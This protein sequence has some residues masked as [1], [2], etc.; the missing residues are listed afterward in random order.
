[1]DTPDV[2]VEVEVLLVLD[3]KVEK[4]RWRRPRS[5]RMQQPG[6]VAGRGQPYLEVGELPT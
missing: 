1:V 5:S 2:E 4:L 3:V 6:P